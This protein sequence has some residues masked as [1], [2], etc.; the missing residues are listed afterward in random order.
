MK[1]KS[2]GF[3]SFAIK[4]DDTVFLTDPNLSGNKQ[5]ADVVLFSHAK[6]AGTE[7]VLEGSKIVPNKRE[8]VFEIVN[9]GEY[10]ISGV[11]VRKHDNGVLLLDSGT[12]RIVIVGYDS[13]ELDLAS[14][15]G[16]GDVDALIIAVGD[17]AGNKYGFPNISKV[18]RIIS[19]IDP[20]VLIPA[21]YQYDGD[22]ELLSVDDFLKQCGFSGA[23]KMD[24]LKLGVRANEEDKRMMIAILD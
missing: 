11:L 8:T 9:N 1:I 7:N 23:E 14:L 4:E 10:E 13:A 12:Q 6:Y 24:E 17:G 3:L 16:M 19:A 5:S 18:E 2:A 22:K 15:K 21:G 20:S